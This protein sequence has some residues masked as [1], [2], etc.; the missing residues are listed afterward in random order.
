M[1]QLGS[2]YRQSHA[3]GD[4]AMK[5]VAIASEGYSYIIMHVYYTSSFSYSSPHGFA[6]F[7]SS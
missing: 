5:G 6:H 7:I 2:D 1:T 3:I 4:E